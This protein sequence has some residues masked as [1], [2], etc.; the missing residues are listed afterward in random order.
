MMK[1]AKQH[2]LLVA[3][4]MSY[5]IN[6]T[7]HSTG[8]IGCF[9]YDS[10]RDNAGLRSATTPI[11]AKLPDFFLWAYEKKITLDHEPHLERG[12]Y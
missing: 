7:D 4:K 3:P 2:S 6:G 10:A 5:A 9:G 1:K 8:K 11:F 12:E